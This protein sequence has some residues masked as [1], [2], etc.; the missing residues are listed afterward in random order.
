MHTEHIASVPVVGILRTVGILR[1]FV[2]ALGRKMDLDILI[3]SLWFHW[4]EN[5][6]L[7]CVNV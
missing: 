3:F 4:V 1:P 5:R 7:H 6:Q 2:S